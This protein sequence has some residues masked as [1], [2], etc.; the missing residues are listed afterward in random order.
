MRA[1]YIGES[2]TWSASGVGQIR[3]SGLPSG[4]VGNMVPYLTAIELTNAISVTVGA[5]GQAVTPLQWANLLAR[6][7]MNVAGG[8]WGPVNLSGEHL[9]IHD[10]LQG[11]RA[12]PFGANASGDLGAADNAGAI[13]RT[14]RHRYSFENLAPK[15]DPWAFCPPCAALR[16]GTIDLSFGALITN[17]TNTA[18]TFQ[19]VFHV[20][21]RSEAQSVSRVRTQ[22]QAFGGSG[23]SILQSGLL[24]RLIAHNTAADFAAGDITPLQFSKDG[25]QILNIQDPMNLRSD[26][27]AQESSL[28]GV[29]YQATFCDTLFAGTNPEPRGVNVYPLTGA[30]T[31]LGDLP[32]GD[33]FMYQFGGAEPVGNL[34]WLYTVAERQ[35]DAKAAEILGGCGCAISELVPGTGKAGA[36][37]PPASVLVPRGI[38]GSVLTSS[39]LNGFTPVTMVKRTSPLA[40]VA[41]ALGVTR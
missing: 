8:P 10:Y 9:R 2:V 5:G 41:A 3:L 38:N 12:I 35:D 36:R 17:T 6:M 22:V 39:R 28:A 23:Q 16:T 21:W 33:N 29:A 24:V 19:S 20:I 14:V 13:T 31:K 7:T 27:Y 40:R 11:G 15:D 32:V 26:D 25:V 18:T 34:E 30:R 37:V 4:S 1:Q